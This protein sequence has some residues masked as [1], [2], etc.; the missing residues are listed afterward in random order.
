MQGTTGFVA[1]QGQQDSLTFPLIGW[2]ELRHHASAV[3]AIQAEAAILLLQIREHM[4]ERTAP[5]L[6]WHILQ[7]RQV[8]I[9]MEA[10]LALVAHD[11]VT[12]LLADTA[13]GSTI[14]QGARATRWG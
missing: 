2:R 13:D 12:W 7:G 4:T 6:P 14:I 11:Q 5:L 8:A 10:K 3:C 1:E 9:Q